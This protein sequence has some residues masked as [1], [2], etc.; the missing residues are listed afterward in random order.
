MKRIL[1]LATV[2]FIGVTGVVGVG[3]ALGAEAAQ[4][5]G[6]V[7]HVVPAVTVHPG[8]FCSPVGAHG[9]YRGKSYV[10]SRTNAVGKP[11]PHNRARWRLG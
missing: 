7:V 9:M 8:A 2:G 3:A 5:A 10:C 4:A 6:S 1:R 11:Y